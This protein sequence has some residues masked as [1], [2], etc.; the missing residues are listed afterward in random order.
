[1]SL[2]LLSGRPGTGKTAFANWLA[3]NRGFVDVETDAEWNTWGPLVCIQSL[4]KAIETR[5]RV[6]ALGPDVIVEWGF[7]VALL[8]CVRYL[9]AAGLES[10][11][12]DG[13]EMAARQGYINRRG[14]SP[15]AMRAYQVQVDEIQA[16]WPQLE[17][18]YGDHIIRTVSAGPTY[19]IPNDIALSMFVKSGG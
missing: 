6:R 7:K 1:M 18:F 11:W 14:D 3:E 19:M 16:A 9:R 5:N 8:G 4:E 10:W 15:E 17:R 2:V 13:D 12:F